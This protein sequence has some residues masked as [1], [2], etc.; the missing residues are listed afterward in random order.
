MGIRC[1]TARQGISVVCT[2][3]QLDNHHGEHL[4][5]D[6]AANILTGTLAEGRL[7]DV[8]SHP[9]L[10]AEVRLVNDNPTR[11]ANGNATRKHS[12]SPNGAKGKRPKYLGRNL[13]GNWIYHNW[14]WVQRSQEKHI[15]S[16]ANRDTLCS[17][18]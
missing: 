16:S 1:Q 7:R 2:R 8:S 10:S 9:H 13:F 4:E 14:T 3:L 18:E 17:R 12:P 15:G 6:S 5:M 11:E